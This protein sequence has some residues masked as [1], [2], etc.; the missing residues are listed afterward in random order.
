VSGPPEGWDASYQREQAAPW[1]IGRPQPALEALAAQGRFAGD[2]LDAGCGTGEHALLAASR[3]AT[4]FG[5]DISPVAIERARQ[6]AADRG[7]TARFESGDILAMP[8]Q[9]AGFD[10]V[11]DSGLFHVFDDND[12][13]HYVDV[14]ARVLRPGGSCL[15]MCFSDR[16][17]GVWGPRRVTRDELVGAF[18]TGW[19]VETI[20]PAVFDINPLPEASSVHAW[21]AVFRRGRGM[22]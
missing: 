6:K 8:L 5:V 14:L 1:D 17:P 22:S 2:L 11:L 15:L 3:G 18:S 10:T 13:G 19:V 7:V 16:Q 21:L 20:E 9:P 12:R 4:A